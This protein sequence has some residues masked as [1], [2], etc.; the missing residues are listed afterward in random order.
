M[1][2]FRWR[3]WLRRTILP[4][5]LALPAVCFTPFQ[6]FAEG[7]TRSH[8]VRLDEQVSRFAKNLGLSEAQ[9]S[10]VKNIL[11]QQQREI[12]RIRIDASLSGSSRINRV[13]DL[14]TTTVRRIRAVLNEEQKKKYNPLAPRS[15]T[16]P[17]IAIEEWLKNR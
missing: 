17:Q 14:Q 2:K 3:E 15:I 9:Q 5:L 7:P 16:Q 4:I 6:A 1:S 12:I 13:R 10:A 11:E 8:R